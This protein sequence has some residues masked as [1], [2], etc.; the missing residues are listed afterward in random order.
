MEVVCAETAS[1]LLLPLDG[2]SL[3]LLLEEDDPLRD[4]RR[5]PAGVG[6]LSDSPQEPP[7]LDSEIKVCF[8]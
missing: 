2:R 8:G 7:D 4:L 3:G 5:T 6:C 1:L